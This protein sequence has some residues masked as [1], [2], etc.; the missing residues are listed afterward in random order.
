MVAD[1]LAAAS[2]AGVATLPSVTRILVGGGGMSPAQQEG[3]AALCPAATV[4]AAYGMTECASSLTFTTL[5]SPAS[6]SAS[7]N[8]GPS[9]ISSSSAAGANAD[10]QDFSGGVYVG[11]PPPGIELA[12]Y[13]P[14]G[15]AVAGAAGG[16]SGA[17]LGGVQ[18][19][20]EGEVLT[21]GPHVM[22]GYW[23]DDEATAAAQLPGGW[24]RTGDLGRLSQGTLLCCCVAELFTAGGGTMQAA[25]L[26]CALLR[27]HFA[28]GCWRLAALRGWQDA[29]LCL[30][31]CTELLSCVAPPCVCVQAGCG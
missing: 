30:P 24:L 2:Q 10:A 3:L 1:L 9:N 31:A 13:R 6:P 23:D 16:A 5:W 11:R 22:L 26:S 18:Q 29:H 28:P 14:P 15:G 21:R 25:C 4:H 7:G 17:R 19:S 8:L 27:G 12:V 20:G